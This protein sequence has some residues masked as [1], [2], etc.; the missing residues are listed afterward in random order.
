MNNV[1]NNKYVT[2]K[3]VALV[4]LCIIQRSSKVVQFDT[5]N[6]FGNDTEITLVKTRQSRGGVANIKYV[7]VANLSNIK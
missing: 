7:Y 1:F 6:V 4:A 2:L 5:K 3:T